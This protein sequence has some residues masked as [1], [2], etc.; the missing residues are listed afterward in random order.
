MKTG[1]MLFFWS[2]MLVCCGCSHELTSPPTNVNS[3]PSTVEGT[4]EYFVGGGT[5]EMSYPPGF[6]L[7]S[8]QWITPPPDS[9]Y[10]R[11]Y[12]VGRV[13]SS[14]IGKLV[15]ATGKVEKVLLTG[16]PPSYKYYCLD[17]NVDSLQTVN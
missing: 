1:I 7:I 5:V 3:A 10:G 12:L 14:Y 8:A 11:V 2:A 9:T 15:R 13:D 6:I 16:S 17:I 4:V